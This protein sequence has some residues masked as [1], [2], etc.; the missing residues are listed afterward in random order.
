MAKKSAGLLLYRRRADQPEVLLAH[1]GGPFW[2]KKDAGAWSIPKGEYGEGEEPFQAALREFEEEMGHPVTGDFQPL[3]PAKQPSGKLVTAWALEHD[4]DVTE[5]RSN[6]FSM[7]WPPKS[8]QQQQFP[9]IDHISWFGFCEARRKIL[10]GQLP[11]LE[12]LAGILGVPQDEGIA[13]APGEG[14]APKGKGGAGQLPLFG[15]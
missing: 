6:T 5:F 7:E 15:S 14:P 13:D 1:P 4:F 11:L 10:K 8:G 2:A 12:E 9:E 3:A